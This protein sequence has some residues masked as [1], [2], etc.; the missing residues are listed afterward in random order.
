MGLFQRGPSRIQP[1]KYI[2]STLHFIGRHTLELYAI[3]LAG[4]ELIILL[5]PQLAG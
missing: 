5:M 4:F 2:S 1:A 3:P